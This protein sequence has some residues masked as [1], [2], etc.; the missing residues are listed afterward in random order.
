MGSPAYYEEAL[1]KRGGAWASAGKTITGDFV[2]FQAVGDSTLAVISTGNE[3][4]GSPAAATTYADGIILCLPF[5]GLQT[6]TGLIYA[7]NR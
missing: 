1:G 6:S 7:Y 5:T 3:V 2:A 4:T